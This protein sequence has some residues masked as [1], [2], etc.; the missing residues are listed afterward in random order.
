LITCRGCI[1]NCVSC[2]ASAYSYNKYLGRQKPAFR[3]PKKITDDIRK[4]N[5]QGIKQIGLYQD[6][7]MG[8]KKYWKEL[9]AALHSEDLTIE[10]L[11]IDLLAP[12]DEE[13]IKE[14][15]TI[16]TELILY[17]CPDS[18]SEE[19][20]RL[21]GRQ[22]SNEDI[23]NT[24]KLCHK[25]HMP[26]VVFFS[27]GLSGD[28]KEIMKETW[29]LWD[30][31]CQF[32]RIA[33]DNGRV[34]NIGR[35]IL[36]EGPILG[37]IIIEPGSLAFDN[38]DYYG[39][40]M[41]IKNLKEYIESQGC[42][43]WH[44]WINYETSQLNK[45]DLI[46]LIDE[47][48]RKYI[49]QRTKYGCYENSKINNDYIRAEADRIITHEVNRILKEIPDDIDR[50]SRLKYLRDLLT[51]FMVTSPLKNDPYGYQGDIAKR[52]LAPYYTR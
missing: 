48:I 8:G 3:S 45:N 41:T 25:Y 7:R 50:M 52:L 38:Q 20:R 40:K 26:V 31:I 6:P 32:N 29:S 28:D 35:N 14:L 37:H 39:Y 1:Y 15:S 4:L 36:L 46:E 19:V 21:Q 33:L 11:S 13:F 18:G 5:K 34:G 10:R 24:I 43:T 27:I 16:R 12:A 17:M 22:Y 2:G 23:L 30:S 9:I 49:L 51:A 44:Q 47:S 42:P